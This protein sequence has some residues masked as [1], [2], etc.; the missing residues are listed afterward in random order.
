MNFFLHN[1]KTL[2]VELIYKL[3]EFNLFLHNQKTLQVELIYL[4]CHRDENKF[5]HNLSCEQMA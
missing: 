5:G 1:K 4:L 3:Y 2:Q